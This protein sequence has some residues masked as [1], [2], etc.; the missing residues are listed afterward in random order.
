MTRI[1]LPRGKRIV[2]TF[3]RA[4]LECPNVTL[5]LLGPGAALT[6][7]ALD[8]VERAGEIDS[9]T[10]YP[11]TDEPIRQGDEMEYTDTRHTVSRVVAVRRVA[12]ESI[13]RGILGIIWQEGQ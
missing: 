13:S 1:L 8:G 11:N 10:R 3:R 9:D 7:Y 2:A 5:K 12:D 4:D 6:R